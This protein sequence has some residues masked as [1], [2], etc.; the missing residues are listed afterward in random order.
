[1]AEISRGILQSL[2]SKSRYYP[3]YATQLHFRYLEIS[4]LYLLRPKQEQSESTLPSG[5]LRYAKQ[6][7]TAF[8]KRY[9]ASPACPSGNSSIETQMNTARWYNDME[10]R[11][12]E[13][14]V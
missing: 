5:A 10:S 4:H 11:K 6:K 8:S 2:L 12:T 13:P 3:N 1:M 7:S 9:W 14:L